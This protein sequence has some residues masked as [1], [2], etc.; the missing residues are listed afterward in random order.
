AILKKILIGCVLLSA[1][2]AVAGLVSSLGF[3]LTLCPAAMLALVVAYEKGRML[4]GMRLEFLVESLFLFSG[5]ITM[6]WMAL[7]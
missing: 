2:M 6:L 7:K 5:V 1:V 4:P 3:F